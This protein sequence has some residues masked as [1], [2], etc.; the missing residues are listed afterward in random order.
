MRGAPH[1]VAFGGFNPVQTFGGRGV[2]E[3][4]S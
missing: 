1:I 4:P 2:I 3:L